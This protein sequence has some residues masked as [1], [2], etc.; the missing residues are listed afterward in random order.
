[1][2]AI[3]DTP[4]GT[5]PRRLL[6]VE[7]NPGD[8]RLVREM[9]R[10]GWTRNVEVA[11]LTTVAEG[12]AHVLAEGADAVLLDLSL[13]DA[14]GLDGLKRLRQAAPDMPVVILSGTDD[15]ALTLESLHEG[16][17]DYLIKGQVDS[18]TIRRS[19]RYAVERKRAEGELSQKAP[20]RANRRRYRISSAG[21]GLVLLLLAGLAIVATTVTKVSVDRL[22]QASAL[23]DA[24]GEA[25][26]A[27][28]HEEA[29]ATEYVLRGPGGPTEANKLRRRH[30]EA[31]NS[32]IAALDQVRLTGERSDWTA[33]DGIASRHERYLEVSDSL[34]SLVDSGQTSTARARVGEKLVPAYARLQEPAIRE[35]AAHREDTARRIEAL[36]STDDRLFAGTLI[37]FS[38]G[39]VLLGL[40][41][42]VIR[43]YHGRLEQVRR[44]EVARQARAGPAPAHV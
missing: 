29:I 30:G 43:S 16:A 5:R 13:P 35:T 20:D 33:A 10:D 19:I 8:A 3:A 15:E 40:F 36:S 4:R 1:M 7:D 21:L 17:Q 38:L 14:S 28:E 12:I 26:Q 31:A 24:Y 23:G 27:A 18:V 42:G 32:L 39:L 6:I 2:N 44:A 9:L 34:F 22:E 25:L 41:G 37:V 11:H